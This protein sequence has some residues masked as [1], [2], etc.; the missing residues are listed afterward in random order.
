MA[1][2]GWQAIGLPTSASDADAVM[3]DYYA[4]DTNLLGKMYEGSPT[5]RTIRRNEA[6]Q[7]RQFV[8]PYK[9]GTANGVSADFEKAYQLA[10]TQA[11]GPSFS[12]A[13]FTW[14]NFFAHW[15]MDVKQKR[16]MP[17]KGRGSFINVLRRD[18]DSTLER[19]QRVRLR[20][21]FA[22]GA[23][24][25]GKVL[26][27]AT[28][29]NS[30]IKFKLTSPVDVIYFEV[31]TQLEGTATKTA[32]ASKQ[33]AG[34]TAYLRVD[35]I[36]RKA[37][38][39]TC[40]LIDDDG[41]AVSAGNGAGVFTK[42]T[43]LFQKGDVTAIP[44]GGTRRMPGLAAW[45]PETIAS[46]DSFFGMNR[47][48]DRNRLGGVVH[49]VDTGDSDRTYQNTFIDA[50][51]VQR[52]LGGRIRQIVMN[53]LHF[54]QFV[55][56][57]GKDT[58]YKKVD[59]SGANK[60]IPGFRAIQIAYSLGDLMIHQDIHCPLGLAWGY[61]PSDWQIISLGKFIQTWND[62]G[63]VVDRVQGKNQVTGAMHSY[64]TMVC[65]NPLNIARIK[66][67]ALPA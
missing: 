2:R 22:D 37:A 3:K 6:G 36:D 38:E 13:K 45:C 4:N 66:L 29:A 28:G 63:R 64:A 17:A 51:H 14:D 27:N 42:D 24:E 7:G 53:P 23:G 61:V 8:Q 31:G 40:T 65:K 59:V 49:D 25:I 15:A 19:I 20:H 57:L 12:D 9:V 21:V 67:P 33:L 58:E 35:K 34:K 43:Y 54:K 62:D 26:A 46:T 1:I 18:M 48:R 32:V 55:K 5:V 47:S 56:E 44:T 60:G 41:A 39:L 16:Q 50:A 11:V 10:V 30:A 52:T